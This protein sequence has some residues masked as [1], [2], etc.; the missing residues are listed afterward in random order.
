[1][2]TSADRHYPLFL[3]IAEAASY[4]GLSADLIR[5]DLNSVKALPHF[6]VGRLYYIYRDTIA[7]YYAQRCQGMVVK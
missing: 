3:S 6:K 7:P 4:S 5:R 1:M 2:T